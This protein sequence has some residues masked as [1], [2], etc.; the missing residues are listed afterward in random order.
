[1]AKTY[2][3]WIEIEE[4]DEETDEYRRVG[5]PLLTSQ[6]FYDE[7]KAVQFA[8]DLEYLAKGGPWHS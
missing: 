8:S 2:R 7:E 5:D 6:M 4:H 1:M 3:V